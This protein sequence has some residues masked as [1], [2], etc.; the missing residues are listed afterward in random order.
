MNDIKKRLESDP[1]YTSLSD[2]VEDLKKVFKNGKSYYSV[3]IINIQLS[4]VIYSS[5]PH[6]SM[7]QQKN[8]YQ[9]LPIHYIFAA[10]N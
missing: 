9:L 6:I 8:I 4:S 5:T 7:A 2:I 1:S 10:N 3:S